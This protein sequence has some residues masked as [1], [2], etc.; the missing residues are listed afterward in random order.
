MLALLLNYLDNTVRTPDDIV[1]VLHSVNLGVVP[2]FDLEGVLKSTPNSRVVDPEDTLN[3]PLQS[4]E[5]SPALASKEGLLPVVFLQDPRSL[6][7]EAYRTIRTGILLSQAGEPPRSILITSG[8]PS[9]GKTT[10]CINLAVSLA[11]NGSRVI[12]I[13]AD[14]RRP[15]LHKGLGLTEQIPG[16]TEVITGQSSLEAVIRTDVM[17]RLSV[18]T[19]GSIP[20]NP[21]ELLGSIE[22][23]NLLH[24]LGDMYDFVL[25]DSP[26]VLAVTDSVILS[27]Y[28]D[29][30][31]LIVRAAS[32]PRRVVKDAKNRLTHVGARVLGLVLNDV[33]IHGGD[34]Y[35]YNRYY[36]SYYYAEDA[37]KRQAV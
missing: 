26:P 25:I 6:A 30:V 16:L 8:Q 3:N 27:R 20:P 29:G 5:L 35:Y 10:S 21:A 32:T 11:S 15:S 2:S 36:Y 31:V 22:M 34:Y 7:A 1:S 23:Q 13:D 14:L 17:K 28:V 4:S 9:E 18:I 24:K 12:L 19:A 37:N 33:N